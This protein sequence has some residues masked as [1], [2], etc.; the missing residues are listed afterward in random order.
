MRLM[1]NV[2]KDRHGT[3]YARVKVPRPLEEAV[4]S[5]LAKS[6][7]RQVWLKRSLGTKDLETANKRA[8]AVLI[9]FDRTLDRAKELL[10]TRPLRDTLSEP[11]IKRIAEYHYADMLHIDDV[12]TREGLGRDAMMRAVAAQLDAAGVR[13]TMP[14]PPSERP[15]QFGLSD[16]D[17]ER[18]L[19]DL[20]FVT[21]IMKA[22][23]ASGDV[24]KV[25]EDLDELLDLFGINLDRKSEAYRRLGLAVLRSHVAALNAIIERTEGQPIETPPLPAIEKAPSA[26]GETL[27]AA[28]EGWKRDR[29]HSP[30]TL[31]DYGRAINLFVELHDDMP[32]AQIRRIHARQF[33]EALQEMPQKRTGKLLKASLPE[34]AQWGRDHPEA[35]KI[36]AAT[37]NKLLGGVQAICRWARKENLLPDDWAD[38]F[39]EMR[40]EEDESGRAPFSPDELRTIFGAP[41]FTKGARPK[42][43]QGAAAFWLP[44]LSLFGGERLSELA[45]LR[46]QDVA[47]NE[48]IGATSIYIA[49]DRKAGRR[50][51][52]KQ[53]ERYVPLHSQL[54][55][56]GFLDFVAA[57]AKG[58]AKAWLFPLVAP[59]TKGVAAFSKWFGRYIGSHGV[60]DTSKVFHSFRHTFTDALRLAD[61]SDE[62][63]YALL[64]WSGGG[65]PARYGAKDKAARF[66]HRL[67]EAV[68]RVTYP[69]LDFSRLN[70]AAKPS[71]ADAPSS[72]R[73]TEPIGS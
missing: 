27:K 22:A 3:Y 45:G 67:T 21:P 7:A 1:R 53:S 68:E 10:A 35:Q 18:R 73:S 40:L 57:R 31:L 33:R 12:E 71:T 51:K 9:E 36:S 41:V 28:F 20:E 23:L 4:A 19:V 59:G 13:Y 66:R 47:H 50:L 63:R 65:M 61:V 42:G 8:K 43:G 11:E 64:G 52:T 5:L 6:K 54:I 14:I 58:G 56:L 25:S 38:P 55:K 72:E 30:R 39:A 70:S 60:T 37:V 26:S 32:V 34:L 2:I 46:A 44:L 69:A 49:P 29:E 16:S 15:P 62:V 48:L 24:S 17:I